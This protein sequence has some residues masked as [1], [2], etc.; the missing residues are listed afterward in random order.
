MG[1]DS[2]SIKIFGSLKRDGGEAEEQ[3]DRLW[4]EL[5][6]EL[7]AVLSKDKYDSLMLDYWMSKPGD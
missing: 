1:W 5:K 3:A 6:A 7:R 2:A 4:T